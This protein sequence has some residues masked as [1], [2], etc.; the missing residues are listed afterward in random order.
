MKP[1]MASNRDDFPAG[2]KRKLAE[3]V[4]LRCSRPDCRK[5]TSGPFSSDPSKAINVGK[6]AHITAAS[7][8][9]MRYDPTLTSTQRGSINNGIWLCAF[10][11]DLV[12]KDEKTYPTSLLYE[13]KTAAEELAALEAF[14]P[15]TAVQPRGA[16]V[17][18]DEDREF[19]RSLALP[20]EDTPEKVF[21]G[22]LIA[23][24]ADVQAFANASRSHARA[25]PL[26]LTFQGQSGPM[27]TT[28][29]GLAAG[30]AVTSRLALISPPGTGKSTTLIQLAE[31]ILAGGDK[32]AIYV[33]LAEWEDSRRPWFEMLLSR[34]AFRALREQHFMQL[35]Y[36]GRLLLLLDG[37]NELSPAA[38]VQAYRQLQATT[39]DFPELGV[40]IGSR[41][42]AQP[43]DMP[44]VEIQPLSERQQLALA[45]KLRAAE[46]DDL[47]D[48]VW[49]T[50][51]LRDLATIPL[52]LMALLRSAKG[53][54]L[55]DTKDEVLRAFVRE[56]DSAHDRATLLRARLSGLHDEV[57][58]GIAC[59]ANN[60][61]VTALPESTARAAV[62]ECSEELVGLRQVTQPFQ[63][64]TA[65]DTLV[66]THL[67]VRGATSGT[68]AFQHQQFQE[69]FASLYCERLM[70]RASGSD[71]Q[72]RK[73]LREEVLNW[74]AW[75][76]SVLF[77]CERMSRAGGDALAAV[78][79]A[80]TDTFS[81]DPMLAALMIGRSSGDL[82]NRVRE[83][84]LA[85]AKRWYD[86]GNEDH[87]VRFMV[88]TGKPEYSSYIW[89]LLEDRDDQVY[90]KTL[91]LAD[92]FHP[93]V[94]GT[95]ALQRLAAL[96]DDQRADVV[97][98]IARVGGIEGGELAVTIAKDDPSPWVV[99][100][101]FHTLA[102]HGAL[103]HISEV[104]NKASDAVW[105]GIVER[106][107]DR[108]L[109][110]PAHLAKCAVVRRIALEN[111]TDP[112]RRA[113]LLL[114]GPVGEEVEAQIFEVLVSSQLV[115]SMR[116]SSDLFHEVSRRYPA[117]AAAAILRVLERGGE[118]P[119]GISDILK[120]LDPSDSGP[121][122]ETVLQ[123]APTPQARLARYI[124]GPATVGKV[125]D[126]FI[127]LRAKITDKY[128]KTLA[129][130]YHWYHETIAGSR[131][132]SFLPAF[133]ARAD[134][135]DIVTITSL[136]DLLHRFGNDTKR[137]PLSLSDDERSDLV[138]ILCRWSE[139]LLASPAATRHDLADVIEAM[140]R[141][142]SETYVPLVARML[143]RDLDGQQQEWEAWKRSRGTPLSAH[144]YHFQYRTTLAAI[145]GPEAYALAVSYL[146]HPRF[147]TDAAHILYALWRREQGVDDEVVFSRRG[148]TRAMGLRALASDKVPVSSQEA[149]EIFSAAR[150]LIGTGTTEA[151]YR[152]AI[153]LTV[154]ALQMPLGVRRPETEA[155]FGLPLSY[156]AKQPL[157]VI[158]AQSGL[159]LSSSKLAEA[160]NEL[161]R[162][163][164][165]HRWQILQHPYV[166]L[167][168]IELFAFSDRPA[169]VFESLD[170]AREFVRGAYQLR[171]LLYALSSSGLP[172]A[173]EVF[174]GL[175]ERY[176]ELP[177]DYAWLDALARLGTVGAGRI[178]LDL[179]CS[180]ES[181]VRTHQLSLWGV[182]GKLVQSHPV[183]RGEL[184][185]RY[186][187][188]DA[189]LRE[190][191][192]TA[193]LDL[194]DVDTTLAVVRRRAAR[195]EA[196]GY[197]LERTM[198][199]FAVREEPHDRWRNA[200]VRFS[201]S[202]TALRKQLYAMTAEQQ[203]AGIAHRCLN[204]IE[205]A[206]HEYGRPNDEPRHPD[207]SSGRPWPLL[208]TLPPC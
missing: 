85:F 69:W 143:A 14:A 19:L 120:T 110:E 102:F 146:R 106:H 36:E 148:F 193:L 170:H 53:G 67:L 22:L 108:F 173:E 103:R 64:A 140:Q 138:D 70:L 157:F 25:I 12:D 11:A 54:R 171:D 113:R 79:Q 21:E 40:V 52:Y 96:P 95:D 196:S 199:G 71:P 3:R 58:A 51:G 78:A 60:G 74:P 127:T 181:W 205:T 164:E 72:A 27:A 88:S 167:N 160:V 48:R 80:V 47:M 41:P 46:A 189:P 24:K 124:I 200:I 122:T 191:L 190:G 20:E 128:D 84:S 1:Q 57:L 30:V 73:T 112:V 155:L 204:V 101:V 29:Q 61:K 5:P 23:A 129:D 49:R 201:V 118:T 44:R 202:A 114:E 158:A 26:D 126:A 134:T 4:C 65:L 130:E 99:L 175:A 176:P 187:T 121:L 7:A 115:P 66:D 82:W 111:T 159:V 135:T 56:H 139:L 117:M 33:P 182:I 178:V 9:G 97:A 149:E 206:R 203:L 141:V 94:L 109:T 43:L 123:A 38:S 62:A 93:S 125:I 77:A 132:A 207:I 172:N 37:W 91:R 131:Q 90:L 145:G 18:T 105:E 144:A 150:S 179:A 87:A 142:P 116:G 169:A 15:G 55:P 152:R 17:L 76:E 137:T 89:P 92:T 75:E 28:L 83:P 10:D 147:G 156:D 81:I 6:A 151:D 162:G 180:D 63:P 154:T 208:E 86:A 177:R 195:G 34:N 161:L 100:E 2:V 197:Q 16:S 192:E 68:I 32:V 31:T 39:R 104:L 163:D 45:R 165:H 50:P 98:E 153:A 184:L 183:L 119:E 186:M 8:G 198:V 59:R 168:W 194:N 35:A 185:S 107:L 166:L 188:E 42:Q 136:A 133:L 174:Q 13:W